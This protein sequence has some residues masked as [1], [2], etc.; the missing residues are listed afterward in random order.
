MRRHPEILDTLLSFQPRESRGTLGP[1]LLSPE[2]EGVSSESTVSVPLHPSPLPTHT[3]PPPPPPT[4]SGQ[5]SLE[6]THH[7]SPIRSIRSEPVLAT[8]ATNTTL[9]SGL[10]AMVLT[11]TRPSD[12]VNIEMGA[13]SPTLNLEPDTP[14]QYGTGPPFTIPVSSRAAVQSVTSQQN[15]K[16][17]LNVDGDTGEGGGRG[18]VMMEG[19]GKG[20]GDGEGGGDA[21]DTGERGE[22]G[23]GGGEGEEVELEGG[24]ERREGGE[25]GKVEGSVVNEGTVEGGV[26]TNEQEIT[27]NST[28]R[29]GAESGGDLLGGGAGGQ[30]GSIMKSQEVLPLDVDLDLPVTPP[31]PIT[32]TPPSPLLPT[33][34]ETVALEIQGE[35]EEEEEETGGEGII[36]PLPSLPGISI[37]GEARTVTESTEIVSSEEDTVVNINSPL[38]HPLEPGEHQL[39]VM[40]QQLQESVGDGTRDAREADVGMLPSPSSSS[41]SYR[42]PLSGVEELATGAVA[43]HL[44][45]PLSIQPHPSQ[46]HPSR[47]HPLQ[48]HPSQTHPSELYGEQEKSEELQTV[49]TK[50]ELELVP[51]AALPPRNPSP[52]PEMVAGVK[53][54]LYSAWI[55]SPWTQGLLSRPSSVTQQHLTCP[56]L[57]ADIKMVSPV[58]MYMCACVWCGH[59]DQDI[60]Y[61]G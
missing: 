16:G 27:D 20:E 50:S 32:V 12:T 49:G 24:G 15:V 58:Y 23:E 4:V 13:S 61:S 17:D 37:V 19:G 21:S 28:S 25:S 59:R 6:V 1:L 7:S 11:E 18:G 52:F 48:P 39:E 2:E 33:T 41:S 10:S 60:P 47:P 38:R 46:P 30:A 55:P 22:V 42:G 57:V 53:E 51:M 45:D 8:M 44:S 26:S 9:P 40:E 36:D 31:Q 56:G 14:L 34:M 35:V 29:D 54:A 5:G 43:T 3:S